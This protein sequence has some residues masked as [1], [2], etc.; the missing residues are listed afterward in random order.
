MSE[1]KKLPD[2]GQMVM[3][4]IKA[5]AKHVAD[6]MRKLTLDQY[7]ERLNVCNTCDLRSG[8]RCTHPDCGCYLDKKAWWASEECPL[9]KWCIITYSELNLDK[10]KEASNGSN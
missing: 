5:V 1:D 10:K 3:N 9:K 6:G 7:V 8:N 2:K 4:F